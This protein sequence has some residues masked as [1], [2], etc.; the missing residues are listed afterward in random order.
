LLT[1]V[2]LIPIVFSIRVSPTLSK[3]LAKPG[4]A[5]RFKIKHEAP[6]VQPRYCPTAKTLANQI[7]QQIKKDI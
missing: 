2:Q 4:L 7:Q 1:V 5:E 3:T 6:S